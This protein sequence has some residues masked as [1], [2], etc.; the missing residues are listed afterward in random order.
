M[1]AGDGLVFVEVSTP[2]ACMMTLE[3]DEALQLAQLLTS[4]AGDAKHLA[5]PTGFKP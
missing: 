4:A 1:T 3:P 5:K 2:D